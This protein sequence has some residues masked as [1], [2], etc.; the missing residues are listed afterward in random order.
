[1]AKIE[2]LPDRDSDAPQEGVPTAALPPTHPTSTASFLADLTRT[3][4]FM[5]SSDP[6]FT[7]DNTTFDALR[8]LAYE[9]TPGEIS[10]NFRLQGNDAYKEKRWRDAVG[11]YTSALDAIDPRNQKL[12]KEQQEKEREQALKEGKEVPAHPVEELKREDG[13]EET[14]ELLDGIREKC[15]ANRA[16]AN[17]ELKNYRSVILDCAVA[18]ELNDK[19]TKAYYRSASALMAL[20][21]PVE[22]VEVLNRGVDA[23]GNNIKEAAALKALLSRADKAK[24]EHLAK[25]K[26]KADET[27]LKKRRETNVARALKKRGIKVRSSVKEMDATSAV[28]LPDDA[29]IALENPDDVD[30]ELRFPVAV[31][32]PVHGVSDFVPNWAESESVE[33]RLGGEVL[34]ERA[35]WDRSGEYVWGEGKQ[36]G[37]GVECFMETVG[38]GLVKVGKRVKM[39]EV[40]AGGKVEVVDGVVKLLVVPVGRRE[41]WVEE[42]KK[43][44]GKS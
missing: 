36:A 21:R 8:A 9:G 33:V 4:L 18:L 42:W 26:K 38:G 32:Y 17:L 29:K 28:D 24:E 30:S 2:E 35:E 20:G 6:S 22:A 37:K 12:K 16:A 40:L 31:L 1:M 27:A 43:V 44:K 3:P 25:E 13:K 14:K 23:L 19:N 41:K 5:S 7:S 34:K 15:L 11:F 39:G 10:E